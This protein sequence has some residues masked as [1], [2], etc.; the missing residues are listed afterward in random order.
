MS[1]ELP[2]V[3][4]LLSEPRP[5]TSEGLPVSPH[6]R[7]SKVAPLPR[8]EPKRYLCFDLENRPLAYW[9]DGACTAEIT[10]FGWKWADEKQ[11]HSLLLRADGRF[12]DKTGKS[13]SYRVA[14]ERFGDVMASAG[15]VYGHN[16]RRHDL[17]MLEAWR[18]RLR[19]PSL[20]ALLTSDTCRD[21]PKRNGL[22]VSLENLAEMYELP[23]PKFRMSQPKWERANQ[24][25]RDGIVQARKRVEGD[26]LLQELVREKLIED[27]KLKKARSWTP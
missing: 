3:A 11:V 26:V 5:P 12:E 25:R 27:G 9:Y 8:T 20:P 7:L 16:I 19:L 17:P 10:A 24:L 21:I 13:V 2:L 18:T 4:P 23:L 14:H 6:E 1:T 22:S 15:V